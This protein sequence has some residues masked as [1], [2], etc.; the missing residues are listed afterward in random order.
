MPPVAIGAKQGTVFLGLNG[1]GMGNLAVDQSQEATNMT[2]NANSIT[3]NPTTR[4]DHSHPRSI[5]AQMGMTSTST[6]VVYAHADGLGG[7]GTRIEVISGGTVRAQVNGATVGLVTIPSLAGLERVCRLL[8]TSIA[9]PDSTGASDAVKS[10]LV[11]QNVLTNSFVRTSFTHAV[12][13]SS[14]ATAAWWADDAAGT[15][16]YSGTQYRCGYHHRRMTMREVLNDWQVAADPALTTEFV[17]DVS[18]V[19]FSVAMGLGDRDELHGPA[20]AWSGHSHRKLKRRCAT[21]L[22]VRYDTATL[23]P[24]S[25]N[26]PAFWRAAAGSAVYRWRLGWLHVWPVPA[27]CNEAWVEVQLRS[28]VLSGSSV[29]FGLRVYSMN[30]PP[31]VGGLGGA[32]PYEQYYV[33]SIVD[34]DD[35]A[36][37]GSHVDLGS[38]P[39]AV[40][41][42]GIRKGKTYIALAIAFDPDNASANDANARASIADLHLSPGYRE[43]AGGLGVGGIG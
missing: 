24:N 20:A 12:P 5:V 7:F 40:S 29:P 2:A 6:G 34:R 36:N 28:W 1:P 27:G 25:Y 30:R 18:P 23:V 9:N 4:F 10:W 14:S 3:E 26:A 13:T 16:A 41:Q 21:A 11:A 37:N 43:P 33:E 8:W 42:S 32:E 31:G 35:T 17:D 15:N 39:L 19:P 22:H 38:L